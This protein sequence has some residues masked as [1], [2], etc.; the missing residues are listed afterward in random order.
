[1]RPHW[2]Q[3]MLYDCVGDSLLSRYWN[4]VINLLVLMIRWCIGTSGVDEQMLEG[5]I[6]EDA[7]THSSMTFT[8]LGNQ[9]GCL[10][11][12]DCRQ[13][14]NKHC[15]RYILRH[16]CRYI[17]RSTGVLWAAFQLACQQKVTNVDAPLR[18]TLFTQI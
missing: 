3:S 8:S 11:H 9:C 1:M 5:N 2:Q 18:S 16:C 4:I 7:Q 17:L 12:V 15:K 10:H 14:I 6:W 13:L